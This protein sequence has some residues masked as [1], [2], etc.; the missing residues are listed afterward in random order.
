MEDIK[1]LE[2]PLPGSDPNEPIELGGVTYAVT[3][4][5]DDED[6]EIL[7]FR[8][9]ET[10]EGETYEIVD[11]KPQFTDLVMKDETGLAQAVQKYTAWDSAFVGI[12]K[13]DYLR[14]KNANTPAVVEAIEIW[15]NN[16]EAG[17]HL[18]LKVLR[19]DAEKQAHSDVYSPIR[20]YV[21]ER[22]AAY[23]NGSEEIDWAKFV[24]TIEDMGIKQSTD[25]YQAAYDRYTNK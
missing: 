3:A 19:T 20:T 25:A 23:I 15:T 6:D 4:P 14:A 11:G 18:T 1:E 24:K 8:I 13:A 16:T 2:T 9:V 10:D 5:L 17:K 21:R 22:V 12:Q 7:I